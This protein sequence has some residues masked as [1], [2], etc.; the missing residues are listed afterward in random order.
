MRRRASAGGEADAAQVTV[1]L[2]PQQQAAQAKALAQAH[3]EGV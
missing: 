1:V 2:S 3:E